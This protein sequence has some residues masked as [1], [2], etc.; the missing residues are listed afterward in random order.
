MLVVSALQRL[1]TDDMVVISDK[2]AALDGIVRE[3]LF[4]QVIVRLNYE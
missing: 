3:D 1:K 4:E 2:V